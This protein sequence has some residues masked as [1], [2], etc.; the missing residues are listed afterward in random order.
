MARLPI[1]W[2]LT[3]WYALLSTAALVV[4]G[5]VIYFGLRRELNDGLND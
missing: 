4:F 2:K 1:R 5:S 3:A